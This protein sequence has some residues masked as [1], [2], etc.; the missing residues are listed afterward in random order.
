MTNS[1]YRGRQ[2]I[3][4]GSCEKLHIQCSNHQSEKQPTVS[5]SGKNKS[6]KSIT[7][8]SPRYPDDALARLVNNKELWEMEILRGDLDLV[9]KG[10][11]GI[12]ACESSKEVNRQIGPCCKS[13]RCLDAGGIA[14]RTWA[15]NTKCIMPLEHSIGIAQVSKLSKERPYSQVDIPR[16]SCTM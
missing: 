7:W 15:A 8:S 9:C 1:S 2:E 4:R 10:S 6:R 5:D 13:N 11:G 16:Y 14:H 3:F 12:T